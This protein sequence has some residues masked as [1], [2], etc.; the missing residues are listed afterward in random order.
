MLNWW[1]SAPLVAL[2]LCVAY[3]GEARAVG[4]GGYSTATS[5]SADWEVDTF[6]LTGDSGTVLFNLSFLVRSGPDA[7]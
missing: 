7:R 3:A 4:L 6:F 5:G 2:L 1:R